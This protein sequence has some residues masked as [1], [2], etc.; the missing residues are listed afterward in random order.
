MCQFDWL[1]TGQMTL[2]KYKYRRAITGQICNMT[3]H[4]QE[5]S[6]ITVPIVSIETQLNF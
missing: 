5:R 1:K 6:S 3:L 4:S 2:Y